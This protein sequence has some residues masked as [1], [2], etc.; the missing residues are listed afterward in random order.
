MQKLK[1]GYLPAKYGLLEAQLRFLLSLSLCLGGVD[2]SGLKNFI[3]SQDFGKR[4][5]TRSDVCGTAKRRTKKLACFLLFAGERLGGPHLEQFMSESESDRCWE[6]TRRS[7]APL[8]GRGLATDASIYEL[9][10]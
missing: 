3:F 4:R 6:I 5:G 1:S 10:S 7:G 2:L 9:S 8:P